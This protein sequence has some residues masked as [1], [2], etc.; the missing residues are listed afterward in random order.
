MASTCEL[1]L[2][3]LPPR[4]TY[5]ASAHLSLRRARALPLCRR[6]GGWGY[7]SGD[8]EPCLDT[9]AL[10]DAEIASLMGLPADAPMEAAAAD[11]AEQQP[12]ISAFGY[13]LGPLQ[14]CSSSL[15]STE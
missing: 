13:A 10:T 14:S 3:C 2:Y 12:Q 4:Q 15:P 5:L 1:L 11:E 7:L 6:T 8:E 9:A